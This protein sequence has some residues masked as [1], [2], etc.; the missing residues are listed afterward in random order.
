VAA[1]SQIA[2]RSQSLVSINDELRQQTAELQQSTE[3]TEQELRTQ[4]EQT[5]NMFKF[6]Q[7]LV[8]SVRVFKLP[9]AA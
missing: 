8:Q 5:N 6:L 7:N 3:A 1:V 9:D 2:E 4:A